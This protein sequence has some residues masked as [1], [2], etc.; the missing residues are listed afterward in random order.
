MTPSNCL[1]DDALRYAE[2]GIS[3]IPIARNK[4][5]PIKWNEYQTRRPTET[6]LRAF[7]AM[8]GITGVAPIAGSVSGGLS[9]RDFDSR[10]SYESF[11]DNNPALAFDLPTVR[12]YRGF[13]VWCRSDCHR[14]IKLDDG[15]F[16]GKGYTLAPHSIH[17]NGARYE[18][19]NPLRSGRLPEVDSKVFVGDKDVTECTEAISSVVSVPSVVS[20][21]SP[22]PLSVT[23]SDPD[24]IIK[25][26]QPTKPGERNSC[27]MNLARGL[28]FNAGLADAD[29]DTLRALV[30]AGIR[31]RCRTLILNP[32][33][34]RGVIFFMPFPGPSIHW[35]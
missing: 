29:G 25:S 22:D 14:I 9:I 33:M 27:I 20:V 23:L 10:E 4:K 34:K 18:W 19:I 24:S 1:L 8:D 11:K 2:C 21:T 5:P 32:S 35:G 17:P 13:H 3:C 26:T 28:K 12:T 15:E 31:W 30:R 16:R 7:F 6:E